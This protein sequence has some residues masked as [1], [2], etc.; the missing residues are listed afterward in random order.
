MKKGSV[1]AIFSVLFPMMV[2]AGEFKG[3]VIRV[4]DGDTIEVLQ[5]N[6]PVRIRLANIDA[7]ESKQPFGKW[8]TNQLKALIAAQPVTVT[9]SQT[10]RYGRIIGR[11]LT[12]NGTEA[13]RMMVQAGAAWVYEQYN[14]DNALPALQREAQKHKLGLWADSDPIPPW[15]WRQKNKNLNNF[16]MDIP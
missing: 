12:S 11:V 8:S 9:Y 2:V 13:S 4:L 16:Y 5:N 7:P 14:A 6:K 10:D 1:I 15:R 3:K